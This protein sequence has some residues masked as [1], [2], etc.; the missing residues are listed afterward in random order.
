M[1]EKLPNRYS[2]REHRSANSIKNKFYGNLR[3]LARNINVAMKSRNLR[4][5]KPLH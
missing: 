1:S 2:D 5:N 3:R 4:F